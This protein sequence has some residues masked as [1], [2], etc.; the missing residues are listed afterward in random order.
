MRNIRYL[1]SIHRRSRAILKDYRARR[2]TSRALKA[3]AAFPSV[4]HQTAH[5]LPTSLMVSLTSYPPR[6][7]TLALT[8]RSLLDQRTKADRTVLWVTREDLLD[9]PAEVLA[10]RRF[11]LEV[12]TAQDLR[13]YKKLVPALQTFPDCTIVTA[14]DD[15]YY[16]PDWLTRLVATAKAS[17]GA[18]VGLRCHMAQMDENGRLLPYNS[19]NL[20]TEATKPE[21]ERERLFPTGIGGVLYPPEALS[22][23]AVDEERFMRLCPVADDVWFFWMARL[24]GTE[25]RRVP[26]PYDAVNWPN[27]QD[28]A[29]FWHNMIDNQGNDDAIRT[30]E[31]E[32][33]PVP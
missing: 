21:H 29:L 30:L 28:V 25:H 5:G 11:G 26:G 9:L 20:V 4:K 27:S 16:D 18:V 1:G 13:S 14:D 6:F 15:A 17:P 12:A 3:V 23:Q 24:A 2:A 19:W 31:A 32:F 8:L 7:P 22:L 33:G 10:L